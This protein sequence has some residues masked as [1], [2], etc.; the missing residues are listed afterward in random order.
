MMIFIEVAAEVS[1]KIEDSNCDLD[2]LYLPKDAISDKA[3]IDKK[4]ISVKINNI[5]INQNLIG[6]E[7]GNLIEII[8]FLNF[9]ANDVINAIHLLNTA[10]DI[11]EISDQNGKREH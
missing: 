1:I 10:N 7:F 3:F 6:N 5:P 11:S 4:I 9:H 8:K 2:V